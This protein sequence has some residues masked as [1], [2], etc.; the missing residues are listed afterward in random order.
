MKSIS[1]LEFRKNA[2]KILDCVRKGKE[3]VRLTYR[4]KPVADLAPVKTEI[5]RRP[6]VDDPFYAIHKI[7][8]PAGK[9]LTNGEI[10]RILN[11]ES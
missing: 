11:G 6:P 9:N 7:A 2:A 10:D 5:S 4:G 1:M 3:T 8:E